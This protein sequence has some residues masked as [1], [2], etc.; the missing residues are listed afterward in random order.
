[1]ETCQSRLCLAHDTHPQSVFPGNM[2]VLSNGLHMHHAVK[3]CGVFI[4]ENCIIK[5]GGKDFYNVVYTIL[6]RIQNKCPII[7]STYRIAE[8]FNGNN[9]IWQIRP[10][11]GGGFIFGRF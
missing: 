2:C 10:K 7:L 5:L 3:V 9:Y 6:Y 4:G 8:K 1:M 11:S